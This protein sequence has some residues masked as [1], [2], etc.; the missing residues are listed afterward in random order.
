MISISSECLKTSD[1]NH[2]VSSAGFKKYIVDLV[3]GYSIL[4]SSFPRCNVAGFVFEK[5]FEVSFSVGVRDF[6]S[7][8]SVVSVR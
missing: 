6:C 5:V 3:V 4:D 2:R 1:I 8:I 7:P